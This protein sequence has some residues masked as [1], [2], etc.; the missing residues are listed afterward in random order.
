MWHLYLDDLSFHATLMA[1]RLCPPGLLTASVHMGVQKRKCLALR[2]SVA[3]KHPKTPLRFLSISQES[4]SRTL[5]TDHNLSALTFAEISQTTSKDAGPMAP[6]RSRAF[7]R[8]GPHPSWTLS[9]VW[10]L[11]T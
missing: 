10:L 3:L 6:G 5:E 7:P 1:A 2:S 4:R 8:C 9:L 11:Y